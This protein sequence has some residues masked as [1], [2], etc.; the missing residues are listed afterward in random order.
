MFPVWCLLRCCR[1]VCD[2]AT[3][4]RLRDGDTT[5]LFA[6]KE[7]WEEFLMESLVAEFDDRWDAC[8]E[9]SI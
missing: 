5:P 6:R 2:I 4:A 7:V 1:N 8:L 3:S 9:I